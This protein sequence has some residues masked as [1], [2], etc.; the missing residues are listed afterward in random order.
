MR[1][2]RDEEADLM[3][4]VPAWEVG[5][6]FGEPI[7]HTIPKDEFVNPSLNELVVHS[8]TRKYEAHMYRHVL[9]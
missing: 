9:T 6:F 4:N 2:V 7:Y 1:L 8:D 5:T 3:K